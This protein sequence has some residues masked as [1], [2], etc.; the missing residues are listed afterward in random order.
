MGDNEPGRGAIG[1][2]YRIT[3]K[4]PLVALAGLRNVSK[5]GFY[6]PRA[7]KGDTRQSLLG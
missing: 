1:A 6:K 7:F 4:R 3:R 2:G 5:G